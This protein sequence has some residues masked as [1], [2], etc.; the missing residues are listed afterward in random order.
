MTFGNI[1]KE[2]KQPFRDLVREHKISATE[3]AGLKRV[4]PIDE[5]GMIYPTA[6]KIGREQFLQSPAGR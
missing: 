1:E 5:N 3:A 4:L 6:F 2:I